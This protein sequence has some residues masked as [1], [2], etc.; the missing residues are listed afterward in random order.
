LI[1]CLAASAL[2]GCFSN[3]PRY[4]DDGELIIPDSIKTTIE[5]ALSGVKSGGS[6]LNGNFAKWHREMIASGLKTGYDEYDDHLELLERL[7]RG[8]R[9][10]NAYLLYKYDAKNDDYFISM[11]VSRSDP[12]PFNSK[13]E[14]THAIREAFEGRG[15][16]EIFAWEYKEDYPVWSAFMPVYDENADIIAVLGLDISA[17]AANNYPQWNRDSKKWNGLTE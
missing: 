9:A 4:D 13:R 11:Y 2:A 12:L 14:A 8:A 7:R 1:L 3:G 5:R 10:I 15:T 16:A 17:S 6:N